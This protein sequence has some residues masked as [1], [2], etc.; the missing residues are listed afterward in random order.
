MQKFDCDI[1]IEFQLSG[2]IDRAH[3][4]CTEKRDNFES[5]VDYGSRT[6]PKLFSVVGHGN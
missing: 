3:S 1:T 4:A 2:S 6:E 5:I